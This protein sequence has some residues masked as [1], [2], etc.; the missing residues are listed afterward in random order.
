MN[1][2]AKLCVEDVMT[3]NVLTTRKHDL[4]FDAIRK[5]NTD[6][7][8]ALPVIDENDSI[9]GILSS[10]DVLKQAYD[11]NSDIAML[12]VMTETLRKAITKSIAD[13]NRELL[14]SDLM[15]HGAVSVGPKTSLRDAGRKMIAEGV[16]HLPVIDGSTE[17]VGILSTSD[18]VRA[19]AFHFDE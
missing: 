13:D 8:S 9:C 7:A 12:S 6:G 19:F 14:V 4:V 16:H 1:T 15:T 5:M 2:P 17:A 3:R 18:F 10:S 11:L